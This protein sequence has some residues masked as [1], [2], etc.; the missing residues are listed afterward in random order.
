MKRLAGQAQDATGHRRIAP[1]A[2]ERT[3]LRLII[4]VS[5]KSSPLKAY[6]PPQKGAVVLKFPDCCSDCHSCSEEMG[7]VMRPAEQAEAS[8][9]ALVFSD[10]H[11]AKVQMCVYKP[12]GCLLPS[13]E[14]KAHFFQVRILCQ[15]LWVLPPQLFIV[16]WNSNGYCL[17]SLFFAALFPERQT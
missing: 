9:P 16:S 11:A 7:P 1:I 12:H 17:P 13:V 14:S 4:F 8:V 5:T 15:L 6:F 10:I 3:P 2:N